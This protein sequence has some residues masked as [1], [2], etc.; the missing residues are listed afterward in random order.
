MVVHVPVTCDDCWLV[1][2]QKD[3]MEKGSGTFIMSFV[4]VIQVYDSGSWVTLV[5]Y[6]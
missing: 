1:I 2:G 3:G 5:D 6:V 4:V